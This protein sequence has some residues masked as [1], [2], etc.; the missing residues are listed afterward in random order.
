VTI[1]QQVSCL[2]PTVQQSFVFPQDLIVGPV[3]DNWKQVPVAAFSRMDNN[4]KVW[5]F[6]RIK[7]K[8]SEQKA[9]HL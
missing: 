2:K 7:L 9:F 4:S 1:I 6:S 8:K 5:L 3:S